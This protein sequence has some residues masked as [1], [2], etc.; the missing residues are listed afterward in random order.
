MK[1]LILYA[2]KH[3]AAREIAKRIA[4]RMDDATIHDL[5]Q[6]NTPD[7]SGFDCIVFGSSIYVG[8][9]RKEAKAFLS[10][11]E[12]IFNNK[13]FGLFLS[14]MDPSGGNDLFDANFPQNILQ[15]AKATSFLGGIYDPKKAGF[16]E[17]L[18]MNAATKQSKY[19]STIDDGRIEEFIEALLS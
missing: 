13:R 4:D 17:R 10:Q 14:G 9:I 15:K 3:G 5:G 11:N 1:T 12:E 8:M 19:L 2:T 7:I 6:R 16:L 18:I